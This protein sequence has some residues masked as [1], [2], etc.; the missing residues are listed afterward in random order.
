MLRAT[1]S[2]VNRMGVLSAKPAHAFNRTRATG[3]IGFFS[4]YLSSIAPSLSTTDNP[5][6]KLR[7]MN[8]HST[9]MKDEKF[10]DSK[11]L[12]EMQEKAAHMFANKPLFG[13]YDNH[14]NHFKYLTY[15]D[16]DVVVDLTRGILDKLGVKAGDKVA[17]ISNNRVEWAAVFF[18]TVGR[19][20]QIVPMYEAQKEKDWRFIVQDS[21]AKVVFAASEEIYDV[22]GKFVSGAQG[23]RVEGVREVVC[24]DAPPDATHSYR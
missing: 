23:E 17:L 2:N 21:G 13:V 24:F 4:R 11:T 1:L 16:F 20:A 8:P 19:G 22:V 7:D 15:Q 5:F 14:V 12:A 3:P 10:V 6:I 9:D 18:A